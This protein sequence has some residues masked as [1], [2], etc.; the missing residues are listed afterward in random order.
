MPHRQKTNALH[1]QT[2]RRN[3]ASLAARLMAE[4][5]ISDYGLAKRKAARQ[6]GA[7]ETE[8][9]PANAEIETELRA[10]QSLYQSEEQRQRLHRLRAVAVSAMRLLEHFSPYLTGPVLDGTAGRYA[11]V[12]LLV[13]PESPKPVEIF[14][15][16]R[17]IEYRHGET[18]RGSGE[19]AEA[20]LNFEW[21]DTPIS[22]AVHDRFAERM[23][24]RNPRTG[25]ILERATLSTVEALLREDS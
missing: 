17:M 20:V 7:P 3:I 22:V 14:L 12:D 11:A 25:R 2:M 23:Q 4:D 16:D 1:Y 18:R 9:L 15:L 24:H 6:L 19:P 8:A 21:E 10:Y 5:G 13:F